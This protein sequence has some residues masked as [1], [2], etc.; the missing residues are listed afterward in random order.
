MKYSIGLDIGISS[1]G[2]SVINLEKKRIERLGAR[3]YDAAENPKNGSSLAAPRRDARS[4]RRR[5]RRRR[6]RVGKVRQFIVERGLLTSSQTD[7]LYDWREEDLDIWLVRVNALER[8]LTDREFA[9]VLIHIAKNRGYRSN[10][11]SESKSGENG[12]VLSAIKAN[13]ELM[14]QKGYLTVAE[15]L[16][17]EPEKFAGRKR[18]RGGEYTHVIARSELEHE[19]RLIFTKQRAFGNRFATEVNETTYI[20]IWGAQRP[21]A[22]KDDIFKKIGNCTFEKGEKRAPK[23]SYAFQYFRALDKL[24]RLRIL[25]VRELSRGLTSEERDQI[26]PALFDH[27]KQK[28][29]DLRKILKLR[30]DQKFNELFY[31]PGK[32]LKD[33]E[34]NIFLSLAEQYKIRKVIKDAQGKGALLQYRPVDL[35]TIAYAL[36]VFKDD[37]DTKDYLSNDY[38]NENGKQLV[39]LANRIF[40]EELINGLLSL[41]FSKFGHLSLKALHKLIPYMENGLS[42][43]DACKK[44]GYHDNEQVGK[45]KQHL[46]PVI[47]ADEIRN[48][49]VVRSLSQT[50]KVVNAIIKRYGS[51]TFMYI[52]LAREMG[53]PYNERRDLEKQYNKNRT[54]NDQ[55][56]VNIQEL[57]P[58]VSDPRGHDILKFKLWQ[59]QDGKCAY[60]LEP[61][62]AENIFEPGYAE[63]DHIIPYSRSFD[64]S[65]SNK[66]LVLSKMNQAKKDRTPFEWFGGDEHRWKQFESYVNALKVNRKKKSLLTKKN[67]DNEEEETFKSRHLNDTRY[68]TRFFKNFVENNLMFREVE[69]VK[70]HV[71]TVNGAYTSL[72]RKRWGFNKN[73]EESD[74]HHAVD[75]VIIAVSQP[76]RYEVS[77]YFRHRE[78]S[79]HQFMKRTGD[80]FPEPWEG[81][82]KE[83]RARI[84]QDPEKL[85][86]ALES[87]DLESYGS[88]FIDDVKTIFISRMPKRS[89]KGQIHDETLRR[90]RGNTE[91]GF[92]RVVTRTRLENIT[93]DKN[94]DF[95]MYGK[96]SDPKTY[97][98][99]KQ[100][101]LEYGKDTKKAFIEPLYKPAKDL[102][103]ASIIRSVKIEEKKNQLVLLR[104]K[105]VAFNSSIVRTEVYQNKETGKFY[106]APVYVSDVLAG[107]EPKKF[108]TPHKNYDNW[109]EITDDYRFL[110]NIFPNDVLHIKMKRKKEAKT[111]LGNLVEWQEGYFYFKKVHSATAQIGIIDHMKSFKDEIGSQNLLIL[112]KYQVDPLGNLSKVHGEKQYGISSLSHS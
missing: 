106:L 41:S 42:Y 10:R 24:N 5:L 12:Q 78:V 68:I 31:D 72:M 39:N 75:A 95:P 19:I 110:F 7:Q 18:N 4:A 92:I 43:Y 102:S 79:L 105:A 50:R 38:V 84:M 73:R 66:V 32:S 9:R 90:N 46:L 93:F 51:P 64:D 91:D 74:L 108:I 45:D 17:N 109:L 6:Y 61:I 27:D 104:D 15:M 44:V 77:T 99:I 67:M 22:T 28:Y 81:F 85:K 71:F 112:E 62:P 20:T 33:N 26:L 100:R 70:Q 97:Q 14:E 1:V 21:V 87:L 25:S 58:A 40:D 94:G 37:Q 69:G 65:N 96:E 82:V 29:S 103:R 48:P 76:F 8:L 56:K 89:I 111:F 13:K 60:S 16:V 49:V 11:K 34:S 83:L 98:A 101:Y 3:L 80:Y 63:V 35:D 57:F 53:R 88:D 47:P 86:L 55:A 52:E 107:R 23:A 54:V 59:Q 36:T 2:W 30:D